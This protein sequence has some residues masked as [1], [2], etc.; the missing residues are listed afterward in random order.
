MDTREFLQSVVPWDTE[1]YVNIHWR[2]PG[3]GM[4]GR[5]CQ[6]VDAALKLV[7]DIA[8]AKYDIYYCIAA[9][10]VANGDRKRVHAIG[11]IC[12]PVDLDID[13][14]DPKKYSTPEEALEALFAFCE[15]AGIPYPSIIVLSGGGL[16]AYWISD[17]TLVVAEWQPYANAIKAAALAAGLK[18]DPACTGDVVRV[19]RVPGTINW[20]TGKPRPVRLL[21]NS[22]D[23]RIDF[24]VAF[25]PILGKPVA[26]LPVKPVPIVLAPAFRQLKPAP[27][28][29]EGLLKD[30]PPLKIEPML[31][32][33]GWLREAWETHGE[34]FDNNQ[35][36]LTT[37]IATWLENGHDL[38][39]RLGDRHPT[40][41]TVETDE[42]WDRKNQERRN[43]KLGWP[44]CHT[45]KGVGSTHCGSCRHLARGKSPLNISYEAFANPRDKDLEELGGTRPPELRLPPE[46]CV[47]EAGYVCHI[48]R[49]KKMKTGVQPARLVRILLTKIQAPS[50]QLQNGEYGIGFIAK[51]DRVGMTEVFLSS[52]SV[53]INGGLLKEL[54]TKCVLYSAEK[55]ADQMV[56]KFHVSWL[57]KLLE[58]DIA[59]RDS[60]TMGWRYEDGK[61]TGFVYGNVFYHEDGR[62]MGLIAS[63]DDDF[64][65]W[66][67][68]TGDRDAWL[69]AAKLLTDR[70]R[71]ELDILISVGFAAPLMAFAGTLYGAILSLWGR[72]GTAKS[73]AQQVA[74]AIFGHPKQTR[75]SLNSTPKSVQRRL[76]KCRNLAAYWDDIQD[77]RHQ[78][79]LFSTM[80]VATQGA[81]GS[82]LNPDATMKER[83]EWQTML[84]AC[85]NAS[86][87]EYLIKTQKS[88]TAGMRRVFE[89]EFNKREDEPGMINAIDAGQVF[90]A[91][92]QNYGMIGKEYA[93]M[94]A[95]EHNEIQR[96]VAE[97]SRGFCASVDGT[98]DEAYWWG[99]CGVLLAGATLAQRLGAEM[100]IPTMEA[101]LREAFQHNRAI[102]ATEGTEGG[103]YQNTE[104]AL[105]AFMN[106]Y[107]GSGHA[108]IIDRLYQNRHRPVD[109][110]REPQPGRPVVVQ[111][112]RD[113]RKI[114]FSKRE[115]REFLQKREIQSRQ[116]FFGLKT[117]FKAEEARHTLGAGTV[118]AGGQELCFEIHVPEHQPHVLLDMMAVKGL[119]GDGERRIRSL[120]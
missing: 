15:S 17:R 100:D 116:V 46:F 43:P 10:D 52:G 39:H 55:G 110:L 75:E 59:I 107:V 76:G 12:V 106:H 30:V 6:S 91:L 99:T 44:K 85:S 33:C 28:V 82:R 13:P 68:P 95:R 115:L 119:P 5:S 84:V 9:L 41:S 22:S 1:G 78:D 57:E 14:K 54:A 40:Y 104:Q 120:A 11:L 34:N 118:H 113:E 102:R 26:R 87:V 42:L 97:I 4:P 56:Q 88:T 71:P 24:A 51:T 92:E 90:A 60:G 47:N 81:E 64:R 29:E 93:R 80:F 69:K 111:L 108:I 16:H 77:E 36:N 8:N 74:A 38:A 62:E 7:A 63:T 98:I 21:P 25:A 109:V 66:Y 83:L 48:Q 19:L 112:V 73:T 72:P 70:K 105:V 96:M 94:L 86:F 23:R 45:I 49:A 18:L 53:Y 65:H 103:S 2:A 31:E 35:W 117:Y 58:E 32:E 67:T 3:I 20:K 37:L 101:F 79:A 89:I 50:L 114:I 61:L 27:L